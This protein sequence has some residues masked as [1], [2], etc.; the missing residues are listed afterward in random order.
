[1]AGG[2]LKEQD[3]DFVKATLKEKVRKIYLIGKASQRLSQAWGQ[4]VECVRCGTL[5]GAV[6]AAWEDAAA[7]DTILLSPGCASFDQFDGFEERGNRF[8]QIVR[9]LDE[10]R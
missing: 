7:G 5:D 2:L 4:A 8:A 1:V 3:V 10:E 9:L 6:R